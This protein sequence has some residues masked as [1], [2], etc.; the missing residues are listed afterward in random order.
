MTD[1]YRILTDAGLNV[2]PIGRWEDRK[3]P[4]TWAPC[5]VMIHH[6]AGTK[7]LQVIITGRRDLAGPLANLH[8]PKDATVNLVSGG[9]CNHAGAGAQ[10]VLD[11]VR[12]D[13]APLGDAG[14]LGYVD[15]P[16]G[17]GYFY[18]IEAENLGDNRDPWPANQL[19]TIARSA[20]AL[21][22]H[23]GWT[24]ARVI[25]HRE[26]SRRKPDPRGFGMPAL[27]QMVADLLVPAPTFMEDDDMPLNAKTV[28]HTRDCPHGD[29]WYELEADGG[30]R[31]EGGCGHFYG[32]YFS[33]DATH[34]NVER[35]FT[36]IAPRRDKAEGYTLW[37][38]DGASYTFGP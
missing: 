8:V 32:S 33:L 25:G 10:V 4:G 28:V 27:R 34:R 12:Q 19:D 2:A 38:N 16:V 20:A 36:A 29:G 37:A 23:H 7:S 11:R 5:A 26:W 3:R 6:T 15:G 31:A 17:N 9:R 30:V 35:V 13:L 22:R 21:C 24:A 18:G 1:L 14:A